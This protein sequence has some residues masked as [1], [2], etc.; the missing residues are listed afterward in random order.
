M[1]KFEHFQFS[2]EAAHKDIEVEEA[3]KQCFWLNILNFMT[4]YKLAEIK[5]T[6]PSIL[7]QFKSFAIW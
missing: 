7:K 5:V 4:L 3:V 1:K 2:F 6:T